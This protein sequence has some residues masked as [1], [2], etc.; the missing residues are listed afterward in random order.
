MVHEGRANEFVER[1]MSQRRE[2]PLVLVA[3]EYATG[4]PLI[5]SASLARLLA[6][7]ASVYESESSRID[8]ELEHLL[9]SDYRCWNGR[10]RVYQ[11][12]IRPGDGRRHR[13][14]TRD[15]IQEL[16]AA[17]VERRIVQGIARRS[18]LTMGDGVG[19]IEDVDSRQREQRLKEL[20]KHGEASDYLDLYKEEVEALS[21]RLKQS[22]AQA[23]YWKG[24][25]EEAGDLEDQV[26][27]LE[28]EKKQLAE[29]AS[30]AQINAEASEA[31]G[32]LIEDLEDLP[33]SVE[34]V[35]RL[36]ATAFHDQLFFTER[37]F[38]D[39]KKCKL[40]DPNIAWRVLRSMATILYKLHFDEELPFREIVTRYQ[41]STPF[42]LAATES[43]T[44]R[45][46]KKLASQRKG[47]YKGKQREFNSHVKYGNTPGNLLR[48]H[49]LADS[50]AEK[51][52][53]DRCVD[54]LDLMSTN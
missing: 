2:C 26:R 48:V 41:N 16:G 27:R 25:S 35:A 21:S 17:E 6:G 50:E 40:R 15:D 18:Q 31:K 32:S 5:D 1:L 28:Y 45:R 39:A 52:V 23:Q 22:D 7:A 30:V 36:A 34:D 44:V 43:E 20:Q 54:H 51:L 49:Y 46:N 33:E 24:Q 12:R 47:F 10:V 3:K 29:Q 53:I 14:F 9:D 8:K 19:T 37:A 38:G 42:E 13:Y 4:K 11:P